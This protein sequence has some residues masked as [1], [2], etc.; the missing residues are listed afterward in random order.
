MFNMV[1]YGSE[2]FKMLFRL[3]PT[4]M[5]LFQPNVFWA[6]S[7]LIRRKVTYKTFK[8]SNLI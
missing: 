5:I 7:V 2:N 8:Y 6:F 4:F 3:P 1:T